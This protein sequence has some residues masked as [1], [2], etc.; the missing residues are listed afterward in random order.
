MT[1]L[2]AV[3]DIALYLSR[4]MTVKVYKFE[5]TLSNKGAY[6]VVNHLP[7]TFGRQV[8]EDVLNVNLHSPKL[9]TGGADVKSLARM[10]DDIDG[11]IPYEIDEEDDEMLEIDGAYYAITSVSQP[12][13]DNDNTYFINIK[14]KVISK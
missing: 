2:K 11:L 5:K 9:K 13:E 4:K 6:I 7:F 1:G 12:M 8:H 14:V 3:E 10:L